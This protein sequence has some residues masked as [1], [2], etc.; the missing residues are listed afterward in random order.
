[1]TTPSDLPAGLSKPALRALIAAGY[2]RLDQFTELTEAEVLRLHG[3]GPT[4][5]VLLR[6]AL[7]E[8]GRAFA[9]SRDPQ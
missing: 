6:A 8:D 5:L 3:V 2:L 7:A 4:A 1:M 9:C